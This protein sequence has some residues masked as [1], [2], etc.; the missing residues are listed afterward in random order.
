MTI[1]LCF[2]RF[3]HC[4]PTK[5]K[6][7][8]NPQMLLLSSTPPSIDPECSESGPRLKTQDWANAAEFVPGQPYCG[9][10][11]LQPFFYPTGLLIRFHISPADLFGG[12]DEAA[13]MF[14]GGS[15]VTVT[16]AF[17]FMALCL[18][19][20]SAISCLRLDIL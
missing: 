8:S 11:E 1:L 4:K 5:S 2:L 15:L 12:S 20:A 19:G 6:E 16:V 18:C 3:D 14:L 10:G 9:R 13:F 7:V 17:I